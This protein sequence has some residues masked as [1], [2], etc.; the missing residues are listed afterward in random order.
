[1]G[2]RFLLADPAQVSSWTTI[3]ARLGTSFSLR[4]GT[5][6]VSQEGGATKRPRFTWLSVRDGV[7]V[8]EMDTMMRRGE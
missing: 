5:S 4:F 8:E 6:S 3:L 7:I 2:E 1:M